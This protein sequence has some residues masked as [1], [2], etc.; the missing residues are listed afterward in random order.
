MKVIDIMRGS[1]G[2]LELASINLIRGD[3]SYVVLIR[4]WNKDCHNYFSRDKE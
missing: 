4:Y 3:S 2:L 1:D